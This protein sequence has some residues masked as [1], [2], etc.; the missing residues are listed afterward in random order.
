MDFIHRLNGE[1]A[2]IIWNARNRRLLAARDRCGV[3]PLFY[4]ETKKEILISSEVEGI[5]VLNRVPRSINPD[6]MIGPA[7]GMFPRAISAFGRNPQSQTGTF[8]Y[9]QV[10][11]PR[12]RG[13]L[14]AADFQ[15]Q[16]RHF[17]YGSQGRGAPVVYS[18]RGTMWRETSGSCVG[19]QSRLLDSLR[20]EH[21]ERWI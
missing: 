14:L 19:V 18:R 20:P 10:R 1:F 21:I 13:T 11:G 16:P 6:Y 2:L 8:P 5:F 9:R 3:K 7:L 17:L 4:W 12:A 15:H